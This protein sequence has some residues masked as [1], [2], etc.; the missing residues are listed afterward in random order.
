MKAPSLNPSTCSPSDLEIQD[1]YG[2]YLV[3]MIIRHFSLQAVNKQS[4]CKCEQA[5]H[6]RAWYV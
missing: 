2:Q 4:K 3:V 6:Y 5:D 1:C